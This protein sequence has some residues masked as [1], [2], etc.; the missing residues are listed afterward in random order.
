[1]TSIAPGAA[2][3][4]DL[5]AVPVTTVLP[6][7]ALAGAL[8]GLI[9]EPLR[10]ALERHHGGFLWSRAARLVAVWDSDGQRWVVDWPAVAAAAHTPKGTDAVVLACAAGQPLSLVDV[11]RWAD[12]Y[13]PV[14]RL[15]HTAYAEGRVRLDRDTG[16][17]LAE[18]GRSGTLHGLG[19]HP[20]PQA[21]RDVVQDTLQQRYDDLRAALRSTGHPLLGRIAAAPWRGPTITVLATLGEIDRA[22]P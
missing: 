21:A 12:Q 6:A 7:D 2:A 11:V 15:A 4:P 20:T 3:V 1:M 8:H 5:G 18:V 22:R 19:G 13:G 9:F 10:E 17:W 16:R 14:R